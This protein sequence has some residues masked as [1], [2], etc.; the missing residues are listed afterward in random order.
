MVRV[1]WGTAPTVSTGAVTTRKV[2]SRWEFMVGSLLG[3]DAGTGVPPAHPASAAAATSRSLR[4][5]SMARR[6]R[7]EDLG[8][9]VDRPAGAAIAGGD[10]E[11]PVQERVAGGAGLEAGRGAEIVA[12]CVDD[13]SSPERR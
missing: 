9:G 13:L 1:P 5:R 11:H 8:D 3:G 2:M 6:L 12:R 4:R 7:S 10:R